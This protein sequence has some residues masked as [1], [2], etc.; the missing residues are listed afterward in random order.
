MLPANWFRYFHF[1]HHRFT[2]IPGKAPKLHSP[3]PEVWRAHLWHLSG[4][5]NWDSHVKTLVRTA[6]GGTLGAYVP[7]ARYAAISWETRIYLLGYALLLGVSLWVKSPVLLSIWLIPLTLGQPFL[8]LYLLA[9]Q[10][11]CAFV[12]NMLENSRTT[13]TNGLIRALAWTGS[14]MRN[15]TAFPWCRF[16]NCPRCIG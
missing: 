1:A 9:K 4:E 7:V 14:I 10:G 13:Y 5:P 2:Q 3:K 11:R 16:I 8:R 15:I 6:F 12:A